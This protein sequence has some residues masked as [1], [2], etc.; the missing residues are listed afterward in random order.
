MG[1]VVCELKSED[2]LISWFE[3]FKLRIQIFTILMAFLCPGFLIWMAWNTKRQIASYQWP[4]VQGTVEGLRV[5]PWKDDKDEDDGVR[6][7]DRPW[8]SRM[9][10]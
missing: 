8:L 1:D 2:V 3:K 7:R 5:K 10:G 6:G 9:S 4:E